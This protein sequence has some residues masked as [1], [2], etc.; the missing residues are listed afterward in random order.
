MSIGTMR[1]E[2]FHQLLAQALHEK[3]NESAGAS[4]DFNIWM[5]IYAGSW[6]FWG[7]VIDPKHEIVYMS[8]RCDPPSN[9]FIDVKRGTKGILGLFEPKCRIEIWDCKILLLPFC[10][11]RCCW[12]GFLWDYKLPEYVRLKQNHCDLWQYSP[13]LIRC[14]NSGP[15]RFCKRLSVAKQRAWS[16]ACVWSEL[17]DSR[18]FGPFLKQTRQK[19]CAVLVRGFLEALQLSFDA[20]KRNPQPNMV[21]FDRS[22]EDFAMLQLNSPQPRWPSALSKEMVAIVHSGA[23]LRLCFKCPHAKSS[24]KWICKIHAPVLMRPLCDWHRRH[25]PPPDLRLW[26]DKT[27]VVIQPITSSVASMSCFA[28][29]CHYKSRHMIQLAMSVPSGSFRMP[30][31]FC[32]TFSSH[33]HPQQPQRT[34]KICHKSYYCWSRKTMPKTIESAQITQEFVLTAKWK[35][36]LPTTSCETHLADVVVPQLCV[37]LLGTSVHMRTVLGWAPTP[38]H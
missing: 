12:I 6:A 36:W 15:K 28:M 34:C 10:T 16:P 19:T 22:A 31:W 24:A 11:A 26:M 14:A 20:Q 29:D 33:Y 21:K 27:N 5:R 17:G 30:L 18:G 9:P 13:I 32:F 8:K 23:I 4:V 25:N 38:K 3:V 2:S 35:P 7:D 37:R 1:K